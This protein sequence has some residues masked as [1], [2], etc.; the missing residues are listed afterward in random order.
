[1]DNVLGV[2]RS[3]KKEF[4]L[5]ADNVRESLRSGMRGGKVKVQ[6]QEKDER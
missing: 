5:I 6:K 4:R 2:G 1:V 3:A